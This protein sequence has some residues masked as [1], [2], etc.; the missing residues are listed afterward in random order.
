VKTD[1]VVGQYKKPPVKEEKKQVKKG[2]PAK[3]EKAEKV[4]ESEALKEM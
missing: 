1:I 3:S 4:K 2:A